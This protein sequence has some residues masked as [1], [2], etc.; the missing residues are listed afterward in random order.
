MLLFSEELIM[1]AYGC[2]PAG[3]EH[4]KQTMSLLEPHARR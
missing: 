2:G 3:D 1:E 4:I